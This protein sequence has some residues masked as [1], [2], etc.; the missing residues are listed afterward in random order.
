ME[1]YID[2]ML[3]KSVDA[4]KQVEH[5]EECVNMFM[6]NRMKLNPTK[7]TF[8]VSLGKFLGFSC[9]SEGHRS[10]LGTRQNISKPTTIQKFERYPE[11]DKKSGN[12]REIYF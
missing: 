12:I 3:V 8:R 11:I 5:L 1:V 10:Q 9:N 2:D 7:C 6:K 4:K